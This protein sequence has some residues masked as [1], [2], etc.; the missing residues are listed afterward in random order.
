MLDKLIDFLLSLI[1]DLLPFY[2]VAEYQECVQLRSG[3]FL[4]TVDAGF[5]WK[6]PFFDEPYIQIVV[7]TTTR[8]LPQSVVT[9]DKKSLVVAAI[10]KYNI[11]DVKLFVLS[12]T[13]GLD[14]I[15]DVTQGHIMNVINSKTEIECFDDV[16]R[17]SR[18]IEIV[19]RRDVKK[20]GIDME[21]LTIVDLV[22][23]K[24]FRLFHGESSE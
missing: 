24:A 16:E 14:A 1:K 5:W 3:K 22:S 11:K 4:R 23:A 13:D 12:I 6:L 2:I 20:Y 10:V 19:V 17:L 15:V 8:T 18:D 7:T 9:S 21:V